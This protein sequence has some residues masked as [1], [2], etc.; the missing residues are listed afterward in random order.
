MKLFKVFLVKFDDDYKNTQDSYFF[1]VFTDKKSC[2]KFVAEQLECYINDD[3]EKFSK[4][5]YL[6]SIYDEKYRGFLKIKDEFLNEETL[7][8]I[9]DKFSCNFVNSKF[10]FKIKEKEIEINEEPYVLK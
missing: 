9:I 5:N 8:K 1:D 7:N 10:F 4:D 3:D 6:E 2:L